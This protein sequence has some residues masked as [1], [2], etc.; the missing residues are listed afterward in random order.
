M[1]DENIRHSSRENVPEKPS[2]DAR[3]NTDEGG[4]KQ[5]PFAARA[6]CDLDP[7]H[8]EQSEADG[9]HHQDQHFPDPS[10]ML[11]SP[12]DRRNEKQDAH[13]DRRHGKSRIPKGGRRRDI[14]DKIPEDPTADSGRQSQNGHAKDIHVLLDPDHSPGYGKCNR[15]NDFQYK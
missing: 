2:A 14:Q 13:K 12:A 10:R 1:P 6:L 4:Q 15:S 3:K 5:I 11:K 9:I 8:G 7:D